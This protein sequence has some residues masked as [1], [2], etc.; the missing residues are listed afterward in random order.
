MLKSAV[1]ASS[2]GGFEME[3]DSGSHRK[4]NVFFPLAFTVNLSQISFETGT[5]WK[6]ISFFPDYLSLILR[7]QQL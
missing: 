5:V 6:E 2:G 7:K 3:V 1:K 4:L